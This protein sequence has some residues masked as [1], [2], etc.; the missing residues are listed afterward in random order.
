[1]HQR[2]LSLAALTLARAGMG[3]QFQ[4]VAAVSPLISDSLGLDKS[5][6]G[7]LIGLYLQPGIAIALPGGLL[8]ARFGDKRLVLVGLCLMGAGG[9]WL[10]LAESF[11]EA[12]AARITSGVG[13]VMLNVLVTKMIADWFEGRE[14]FLAMSILINSWPIGIGLA[15]LVIGPL[16]EA[17]DWH[18][19]ILCSAVMAAV[20]FLVVLTIYRA[21]IQSAPPAL[22][23]PA[24]GFGVGSLSAK[25]WQLLLIGSLPWMLYNAA[26]QIEISF[27]P[28]IFV[29]SG[30]S[31]KSAGSLVAVTTVLFVVGVQAGGILLKQ[32]KRPDLVCYF[33]IAAWCI[34]LLLLTSS[35]NPLPWLVVGGLVG[36]IPAAALVSLPAE[37]LRVASRSAGMGIFFTVYYLGCA[38]LPGFAGG[39]YDLYGGQS[40]IW[41]TAGVAFAAAPILWLFRREMATQ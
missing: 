27:L 40:A 12:T 32:A 17:A 22:T 2:W 33:A 11:H 5:Q 3:F 26:F 34:S 25:E 14:R 8:G 6:L 39:L 28:S 38:V 9:L 23:P 21:P 16:S 30:F 4:S 13:A 37:F 36:G 19:G 15:L 18:W 24:S 20:G 1:M 35:T 7:W 10:S 29:G 41:M 31:I